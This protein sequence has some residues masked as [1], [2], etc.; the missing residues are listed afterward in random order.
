MFY[1]DPAGRD[2]KTPIIII[3]QGSEPPT[4]TGFFDVWDDSLWKVRNNN[5]PCLNLQ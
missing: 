3:K 1:T 2:L 4:F 5:I